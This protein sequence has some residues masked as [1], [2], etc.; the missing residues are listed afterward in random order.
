M[1]TKQLYL[2]DTNVLLT[3]FLSS[4]GVGEVTDFMP[5][6]PNGENRLIR[7][8]TTVRGEVKYQL[9]CCPR[10]K[11]AEIVHTVV[12]VS[13]REVI[14]HV[15]G[16][17]ELSLRLRGTVPLQADNQDV[18]AEFT[19]KAGEMIDFLPESDANQEVVENYYLLF[20]MDLLLRPPL[21]VFRKVSA[22]SGIGTKEA[23]AFMRWIEDLF[24]KVKGDERLGI[25]YSIDGNRQLKEYTPDIYGE[26]ISYDFWKD[27]EKKNASPIWG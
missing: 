12:R 7:R 13:D 21:F 9:R 1:K 26:R 20:N 3:R 16:P 2:P 6:D 17:D 11:Y 5:V 8:V 23:G 27:I 24:R 15:D 14:F 18:G 4:E 25:M 10:F 22:V 19:L